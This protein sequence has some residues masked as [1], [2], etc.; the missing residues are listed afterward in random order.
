MA[1]SGSL[2]L[3]CLIILCLAV[4]APHAEAAISCS[5]VLTKLSPCLS[6]IKNGGALPPACCS[7]AKSLNDAASTTPDLQAVCS[8]VKS[9]LPTLK[10]NPAYVNSIPP[11]CGV[12]L[13]YKYSP[14]VDCSK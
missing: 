3:A 4:T 13:P 9:L 8:C 14:T 12:N 1:G 11:K 2:K 5:F 6:Y 10:A 7:G